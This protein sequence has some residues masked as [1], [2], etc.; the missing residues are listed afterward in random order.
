MIIRRSTE[1]LE[2]LVAPR[3]KRIIDV[4]SGDGNVVRLLTRSGA[5]VTGIE[6]QPEQLAKARASERAFDEDYV[7]GT[8]EA[9]PLPDALADV[10]VFFNSLHHVPVPSMGRAM[11]EAARVLKPGGFVYVS[12]PVAD[13]AFFD[14]IRMV[15]DETEVR[16]RAYEAL[17]AADQVGLRQLTERFFLSPMVIKDFEALR[18][19]VVGADSKRKSLVDSLE[20]ELR[21]N[22]ERLGV[23]TK[24]G[25]RFE[26]PT[27]VNLLQR[28]PT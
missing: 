18:E 6:V 28:R 27:R 14:T 2:E 10:V 12:E 15:D 21:K 23:K 22:L 17:T 19:R 25:F 7:E 16:A 20:A 8:A 26:Q 4:G 13:G 24:D 9:M 5:R 3:G 1:V 11:A